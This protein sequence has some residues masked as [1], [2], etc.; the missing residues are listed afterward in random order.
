[1]PLPTLVLFATAVAA[2]PLETQKSS[3]CKCTAGG[4]CWPSQSE[5]TALSVN[6]T[7]PVFNVVPPGYYCHDPNYNAELCSYA[8]ANAQSHLWV[9]DQLGGSMAANREFNATSWWYISDAKTNSC[10]QGRVPSVGVNA[11]LAQDVQAALASAAQYNLKVHV[12][13]TGRVKI[14]FI[15]IVSAM[16]TLIIDMISSDVVSALVP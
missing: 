2:T 4:S 7:H 8:Q 1:M 3:G 16:F 14:Y 15:P 11:T 13:N 10:G 6:L 12:K 9:A 5:W